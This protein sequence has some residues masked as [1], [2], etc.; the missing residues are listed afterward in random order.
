[1][2][3][4]SHADAIAQRNGHTPDTGVRTSLVQQAVRAVA[5]TPKP[6]KGRIARAWRD[7]RPVLVD[8]A[9]V[10]TIVGGLFTINTTTGLISSGI[11]VLLLNAYHGGQK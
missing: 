2:T 4:L 3:F 11:A 8:I 6:D 1:M 10:G 5:S 7:I 9:G